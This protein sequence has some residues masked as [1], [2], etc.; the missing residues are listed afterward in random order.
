[1]SN[2]EESDS[3]VEWVYTSL[4]YAKKLLILRLLLIKKFIAFQYYWKIKYNNL[5]KITLCNYASH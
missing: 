5:K 3:S 1:M 2:D 4:K